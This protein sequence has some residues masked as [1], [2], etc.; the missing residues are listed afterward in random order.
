MTFPSAPAGSA[1][2]AWC[3]TANT[4][5]GYPS[6][7][8]S[9][10]TAGFVT[11]VNGFGTSYEIYTATPTLAAS[12]TQTS[13]TWFVIG[14]LLIPWISPAPLIRSQAVQRASSR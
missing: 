6:S 8:W 4:I 7:P 9:N 1:V 13:G 12:W 10:Y 14:V 11:A 5:T 2:S 3:M